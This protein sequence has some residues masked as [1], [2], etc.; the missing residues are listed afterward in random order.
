MFLLEIRE[1]TLFARVKDIFPECEV[2][3]NGSPQLYPLRCL[4]DHC[5]KNANCMEKLVHRVKYIFDTF[6]KA[7]LLIL[8][9]A[10][11][12]RPG[13]IRCGVFWKDF[14]PPYY[15]TINRTSW[16]LFK[17][18]GTVYSWQLPDWLLLG[19]TK[20]PE[21]SNQLVQLGQKNA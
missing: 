7:E 8:Y 15:R 1:K 4:V 5:P 16:E 13:S 18:N 3:I 19:H 11:P 21:E 10:Y 20:A 12:D 17:K 2:L 14:R 9:F 6:E